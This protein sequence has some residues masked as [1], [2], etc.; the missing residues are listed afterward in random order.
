LSEYAN[1]AA[2]RAGLTD[3][4]RHV[5]I[6][7]LFKIADVIVQLEDLGAESAIQLLRASRDEL[8]D[9]LRELD[10]IDKPVTRQ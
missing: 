9:Q 2:A 10:Q 6:E 8:M 1:T 7:S 5:I 4:S 3:H